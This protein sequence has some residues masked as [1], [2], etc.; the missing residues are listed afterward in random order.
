MTAFL[1]P[2]YESIF[3]IYCPEPLCY[4]PFFCLEGQERLEHF[5]RR[6]LGI[7]HPIEV[8]FAVRIECA[9]PP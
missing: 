5:L 9:V 1:L 7:D 3:C 2:T 8:T 4:A 6:K